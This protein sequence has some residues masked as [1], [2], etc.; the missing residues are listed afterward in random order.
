MEEALPGVN[1]TETEDA[2]E[3][4]VNS[5]RT[6]AFLSKHKC[7]SHWTRMEYST[8]RGRMSNERG[9]EHQVILTKTYDYHITEK[10]RCNSKKEGVTHD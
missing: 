7:E 5:A 2:N 4:R 6:S 1:A 8:I 3:L 9:D 10:E